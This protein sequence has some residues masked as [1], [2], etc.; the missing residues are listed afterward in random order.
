MSGSFIFRAKVSLEYANGRKLSQKDNS[1]LRVFESA[2]F[3]NIYASI[4]GPCPG[5]WGARSTGQCRGSAA[6]WR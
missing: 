6:N 3:A 5:G 1:P 4:M 2:K